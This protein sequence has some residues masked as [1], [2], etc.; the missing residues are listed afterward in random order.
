MMIG[1]TNPRN[2]GSNDPTNVTLNKKI[3][4]LRATIKSKDEKI[5]NYRSII[6]R[7]KEEFMKVEEERSIEVAKNG[8][9][10]GKGGKKV[11]YEIIHVS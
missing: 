7:L 5:S 11:V 8:A 1:V 10:S 6:I 3:G 9:D 4:N 2:D